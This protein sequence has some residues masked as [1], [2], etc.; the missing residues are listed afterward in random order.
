[1]SQSVKVD[2][3]L[4]ET[5]KNPNVLYV[6]IWNWITVAIKFLDIFMINKVQHKHL[7]EKANLLILLILEIVSTPTYVVVPEH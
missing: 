7:T 3:E 6:V 4:V 5:V 1:M 2:G